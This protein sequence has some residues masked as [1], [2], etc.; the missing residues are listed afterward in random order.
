MGRPMSAE[1]KAAISA[2][3]KRYWA[4][5]RASSSGGGE[6]RSPTDKGGSIS[7]SE[8]AAVMHGSGAAHLKRT[9]A[10]VKR[11]APAP[12]ALAPKAAKKV[13]AKTSLNVSTGSQIS[14]SAAAAIMF[15]S[16][17]AAKKIAATKGRS[18][19]ARRR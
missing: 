5:R 17:G 12:K 14:R 11:S 8:A 2:G 3:M 19:K 15:G 4:E 16:K 13:T 1:H 9:S 6:R 7:R 18:A 10:P